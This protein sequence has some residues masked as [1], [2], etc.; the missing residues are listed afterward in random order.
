MFARIINAICCVALLS[1]IPFVNVNAETFPA[2][3][4]NPDQVV[5][6]G[7]VVYLLSIGNKKIYRWSMASG[8]YLSPV[9]VG[10]PQGAG[11][12]APSKMAVSTLHKRIYLGYS[13]GAIRYINLVGDATEMAFASTPYAVNGLALAGKYVLAQDYSGAWATHH[14][15]DQSGTKT[16]SKDWNFYSADYAWDA[17][18]SRIFYLQDGYNP[19]DLR[20]EVINQTTGKITGFGDSPYNGNYSIQQPIRISNDGKNI[21]L[22]SGNFFKSQ[23]LV[24]GGSV[25]TSF[26]DASW[27]AAGTVTTIR[28]SNSA[29]LLQRFDAGA[30]LI[31]QKT[32]DGSAIGVFG[33]ATNKFTIVTRVNGFVTYTTYTASDDTDGDGV[34]NDQDAFPLDIAASIDTD[35]DGYPDKWNSGRSQK[36]STTGLQLDAFPKDA[37]CYLKLSN[38]IKCDYAALI[39]PY[40]P[41]KVVSDGNIVYLLSKAS[42]RVYRWSI[43]D[44]AYISPL[45]V[46]IAQG[47]NTLAPNAI[48][49]STDASRLYLGYSTGAIQ[50]I[51]VK[52]AA[53]ERLFATISGGVADLFVAGKYLIARESAYYGYRSIINGS[54]TVLERAW[55]YDLENF[56]DQSSAR[57]YFIDGSYFGYYQLDQSTGKQSSYWERYVYTNPNMISV[58]PD[59]QKILL[60]TGA[61]YAKSTMNQISSLGY[62]LQ[63]SRWLS[64][65]AFVGL[66]NKDGA[67]LL[68]RRSDTGQ[69]L[70]QVSYTGVPLGIYG[71]SNR[72]ALL[73]LNNNAVTIRTFVPSNDTDGDGVDNTTDAFPN[74]VAASVDSDRDG[75][76]DSW[77]SG[78]TQ[79]DST[80]GLTLDAFAQDAACYN[81]S[82][83]SGGVCN[84]AATVPNFTP[85]QIA[86]DGTTVYLLSIANKRVYRKDIATG[87]YINPLV[88]GIKEGDILTAPLKMT[89]ATEQNRLYLLYQSG[90]I[91]YIKLGEMKENPF[92][93]VNYS[94]SIQLLAAGN[95]LV[96]RSNDSNSLT[97]DQN[98]ALINSVYNYRSVMSWDPANSRIYSIYGTELMYQ[99]LNPSTGLFVQ[100]RSEYSSY[101]SLGN[102]PVQASPDGQKI[103]SATGSLYDS[104]DL[105]WRSSL[106]L[107][108]ALAGS[109]WLQ[110]NQLVTLTT[111]DS[112]TLLQR[113]DSILRV[114]EQV[115]FSGTALGVYGS[116]QKM[117]VLVM[118]DGAVTGYPYV[119]NDDSDGDGVANINDAFPYDV[120][121]AIDSDHDGYPDSWNSGYSQLDSVSGLQLDA[122]PQDSA[123]F[124]M[125]QS[126]GGSCDIAS[127]VGDFLPDQTVSDGNI[128]YLL[129]KTNKR[130][131][132]WSIAAGAYLNPVVV[133]QQ[134]GT[135]TIAP[136][137]IAVQ[138][139]QNRLYLGYGTGAL[140]YID[141]NSGNESLLA[142][143]A[144]AVDGLAVAGNYLVVRSLNSVYGSIHTL[145]NPSGSTVEQ[146]SVGSVSGDYEWD[147]ANSRLY[148]TL[149]P[150]YENRVRYDVINPVTGKQS[151]SGGLSSDK[152][153][154]KPVRVS[155][156]GRLV[157]L[158]T[159]YIVNDQDMSWA[160]SLGGAIV[161]AKWFSDGSLVTL[162]NINGNTR[163][164]RRNARLQILEEVNYT[165]TPLAIYGTAS[166]MSVVLQNNGALVFQSYIPNNDSDGDGVNNI[167]DAFPNDPAASVD[168]DRDGYPDTWNAGYS[169]SD[170]TSGL[171]LDAFA[172]DASCSSANQ[173]NGGVC[174]YSASVPAFTP[175][176]V[177]SDGGIV[178]LLDKANKRVYR[179][180]MASR[181]YIDSLVVG[182][183]QAGVLLAPSKMA[184]STSHNRLY[185]GYSTGA[186]QYI[187]LA[188]KI[189]QPFA[190]LPLAVKGLGAVG[191]YL[192]AQDDSGSY[193]THYVLSKGGEITDT[194]GWNY[195]SDQYLWDPASSRVYYITD[196]QNPRSLRY[197]TIGQ[198]NG[199]ITSVGAAPDTWSYSLR[200][201]VSLSG[202]G[203]QISL[204]S[205]D[206]FSTSNLA[207]TSKINGSFVDTQWLGNL[208]A[209]VESSGDIK[210]WDGSNFALLNSFNISGTPLKLLK[211]GDD[212]IL[213]RS[214]NGVITFNALPLGDHDG[215]G[216]PGWWEALYGLDD[217]NASDAVL[218]GDADGLSNLEEY[219]L[220]TLP[221]SVDT[222]GEGLSDGNEIN[223]RHT[224]P[225]R[226]D[227]DGDGLSDYQELVTYNTN[228]LIADTDGDG[229]SDQDEILGYAT[230]PNNATSKP[231]SIT[232]MTQL[233]ESDVLPVFWADAVSNNANWYVDSSQAFGGAKSLRSGNIGDS[234]KSGVVLSG[235]FSAGTLQF[236]AKVDA[237][238]CCDK[239]YVYVDGSLRQ[240]IAYYQAVNWAQFSISLTSGSHQIEWRYVKDSSISTVNDSVWID[241]VTFAAF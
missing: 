226:A 151:N 221:T 228:A 170:S 96:L 148:Y 59:G 17:K 171:Q 78:R 225:L 107:N 173:G 192:L 40:T 145:F 160:A 108:G 21:L 223:V 31:D 72:M 114:V 131:Y 155:V 93:S 85:D 113:R 115:S 209:T 130:V 175:D 134:I 204:S 7:K 70:E 24:F 110:G 172:Q 235:L 140:S 205:G 153:V 35:G 43:A 20:Y 109:L 187:D 191:D 206:V 65:N 180:S 238:S 111:K 19:N 213:V 149:N 189:E 30:R 241:N 66:T 222:D 193:A 164:Q 141:L 112:T 202:D 58:S 87:N 69:L 237:E 117:L 18:T 196:T 11:T 46:G 125:A 231:Q 201:P 75:Y 2:P 13:T 86:S 26:T 116:A 102:L 124:E 211:D 227:T 215:D 122:F 36:N 121:A 234:E 67:T 168:S 101:V 216:L 240:I 186:I 76:P 84:Y 57:A 56:W 60:G 218:D 91:R 123:C 4:F 33:Y 90:A 14:I 45:A 163:L 139:N 158:G 219:Q 197:E 239:L 118:K 16:D 165:G 62:S 6:D 28:N 167:S 80:T 210:L 178:Y 12:L 232:M 88:V 83:G 208:L 132:R 74:D 15:F 106:G 71:N 42:K 38:S 182:I 25:G 169:Q 54:G 89:L 146:Y 50:Y 144:S 61:I 207:R 143:V 95:Y 214:L 68:Q 98:A 64:N 103:L 142:G 162:S 129:S 166:K 55:S 136:D 52:T 177:V 77:N 126:N 94:T 97:Y 152:N 194:E 34:K 157:L 181:S 128:I 27:D 73:T 133:S 8:A 79:A 99:I 9:T 147:S 156:N 200:G 37:F 236:Y 23:G 188:E 203:S 53:A 137:K 51:T 39:A 161:D 220:K 29:T 32:Y 176:Q 5:S 92:L 154:A 1:V 179:W 48:A 47:A 185:L 81:A 22:G 127:A 199:K 174:D 190:A 138:K 120:S 183:N 3:A 119:P 150:S 10:L 100:S 82:H 212:L 41:D 104:T 49:L 44:G 63:S 217:A 198:L 230:D 159:G 224:D 135:E 233:F 229:F 195:Y 105:K 184:V